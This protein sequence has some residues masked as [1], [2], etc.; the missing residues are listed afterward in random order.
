MKYLL[1]VLALTLSCVTPTGSSPGRVG[2]TVGGPVFRAPL[3]PVTGNNATVTVFDTTVAPVFPL[4]ERLAV[5]CRFDQA[6]TILY[7]VERLGSSTWRTVNG[8]GDAV[9]A[10]TDF[11]IDYLVQ[12]PNNRIQVVTGS[13]GPTVA[14]INVAPIYDRPLAL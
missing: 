12:G 13:T 11:F 6:V 4:P 14:E 7:Q 3:N 1:L 8:S 9:T 5:T 10:N 2:S